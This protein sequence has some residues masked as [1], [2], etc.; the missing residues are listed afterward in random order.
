MSYCKDCKNYKGNIPHPTGFGVYE[1]L[2][3]KLNIGRNP[4]DWSCE[5]KVPLDGETEPKPA[6]FLQIMAGKKSREPNGRHKRV[7]E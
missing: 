1:G 6:N 3:Y 7:G 5:L 4:M 2:C